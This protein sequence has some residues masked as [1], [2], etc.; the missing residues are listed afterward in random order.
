MRAN[1]DTVEAQLDWD[2]QMP[3]VKLVLDQDRARALGL[4][5]QTVSQSL[6]ALVTGYP[7]TTVRDRTEKVVVVARAIASQRN[8]L[9]SIGDLTILAR[10]GVPVPLAQSPASSR[11][12]RMRSSGAATATSR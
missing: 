12:S 2:G 1:R 7:V 9:G 11:A 6:Q 4:D 8:D 5:P 10:N 3:S